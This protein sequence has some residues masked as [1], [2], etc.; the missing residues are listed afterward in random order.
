MVS[1]FKPWRLGSKKV[2]R[3]ESQVP[4]PTNIVGEVYV[5]LPGG[6][7]CGEGDIVTGTVEFSGVGLTAE[8]ATAGFEAVGSEMP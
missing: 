3:C 5:L 6:A 1:K 8:R 4:S 7:S 2:F